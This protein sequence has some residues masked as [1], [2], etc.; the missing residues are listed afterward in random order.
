M[1]IDEINGEV[2]NGK[3]DRADSVISFL[4]C[5]LLAGFSWSFFSSAPNFFIIWQLPLQCIIG[6]AL[7]MQYLA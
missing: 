6:R 7:L 2:T 5:P 4:F 1:L 3:N